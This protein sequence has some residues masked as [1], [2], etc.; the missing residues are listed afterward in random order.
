MADEAQ[1]AAEK[2]PKP[3]DASQLEPEVHTSP[4]PLPPPRRAPK[5][6]DGWKE[7][8]DSNGEKYYYNHQL[9]RSQYELPRSD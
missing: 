8:T 7:A 9:G 2:K 3:E 4:P 5:L 6:P 1:Q